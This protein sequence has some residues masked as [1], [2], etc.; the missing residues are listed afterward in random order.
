MSDQCQ[1]SD[2]AALC[3]TQAPPGRAVVVHHRPRADLVTSSWPT[4]PSLGELIGDPVFRQLMASDR[5][6]MDSFNGLVAAV[7]QKLAG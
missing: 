5:V 3:R 2:L 1:S 7:R 6:S 4:E